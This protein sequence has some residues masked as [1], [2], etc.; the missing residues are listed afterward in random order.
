LAAFTELDSAI[1]SVMPRDPTPAVR[2]RVYA[3]LDQLEAA[4]HGLSI[5]C[6]IDG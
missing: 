6:D 1:P 2:E 3:A 5:S 4:W